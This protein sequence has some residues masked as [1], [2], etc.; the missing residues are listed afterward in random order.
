MFRS[1]L[2][3]GSTWAQVILPC[4]PVI[5]ASGQDVAAIY[6]EEEETRPDEQRYV[7]RFAGP[8]FGRW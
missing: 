6:E 8:L 5:S 7:K 1:T 2:Q 3:D 4:A